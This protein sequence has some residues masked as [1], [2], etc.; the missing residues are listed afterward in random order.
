MYTTLVV[1]DELMRPITSSDRSGHSYDVVVGHYE[2]EMKKEWQKIPDRDYE[3]SNYG[4]VRKFTT[5]RLLSSGNSYNYPRVK[6]CYKAKYKARLVSSLVIEAFVG[7]RPKGMFCCHND[8]N[9]NNNLITNLRYDTPKGNMADTLIH[10]THLW[11]ANNGMAKLSENDIPIIRELLKTD[12]TNDEI[13]EV[14]NVSHSTI[15][16]IKDDRTWKMTK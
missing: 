3:V 7:P 13:G 8:G 2:V 14:F 10:G 1:A 12:M 9:P 6:I 4:D 5:K 11:G 16:K 15:W